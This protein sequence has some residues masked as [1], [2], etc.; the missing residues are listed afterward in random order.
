MWEYFLLPT[1]VRYFLY[2]YD[3][4]KYFTVIV[5]CETFSLSL[6]YEEQNNFF[7]LLGN[8]CVTIIEMCKK[9]F[10]STRITVTGYSFAIVN[11]LN[12]IET[13]RYLH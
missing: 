7:L 11:C 4:W 9:C 1:N 8:A 5:Q 10:L 12:E 13:S 2:R 6:P 3:V